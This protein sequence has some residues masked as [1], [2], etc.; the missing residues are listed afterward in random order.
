[1][2]AKGKSLLKCVSRS[3]NTC[4]I[5]L[6]PIDGL[7]VYREIKNSMNLSISGFADQFRVTFLPC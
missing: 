5:S 1:M 3:V 7:Q 6:G 2:L 4:T